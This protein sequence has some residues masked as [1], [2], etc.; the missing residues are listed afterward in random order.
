M[1]LFSR[2]MI[3]MPLKLLDLTIPKRSMK[4]RERRLQLTRQLMRVGQTIVED[5]FLLLSNPAGLRQVAL[6]IM[7]RLLTP[8]PLSRGPGL[9]RVATYNFNTLAL[10][11]V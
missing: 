11:M 2:F 6:A 7:A 3:G 10:T 4:T 1:P 8:H 5:F 9:Y